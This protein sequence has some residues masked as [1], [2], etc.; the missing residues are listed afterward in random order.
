M[1]REYAR[2]PLWIWDDADYTDLSPVAQH[3]DFVLRHGPEISYCGRVDW[4]PAR[5]VPRARGWTVGAIEAAAAEY[6]AAGFGLF[7]S[8]T[9]EALVIKHIHWDELLRN[10][11]MA[12]ALVKA[13]QGLAS[14]KLRAGVVTEVRRLREECPEYSSWTHPMSRA[15]LDR[16]LAERSLEDFGITLPITNPITNRDTNPVGNQDRYETPFETGPDYQS[17]TVPNADAD[18]VETPIAAD[19]PVGDD[20]GSISALNTPRNTAWNTNQDRSESPYANPDRSQSPNTSHP[21]THGGYAMG[22]RHVAQAREPRNDPPP[23]AHHPEHP[24][25]WDPDCAQCTK[26]IEQRTAWQAD[27]VLAAEPPSPFC[28]AHPDGTTDACGACGDARKARRDHDAALA[29]A[30]AAKHT[31]KTQRAAE[32]RERAIANCTLCDADGFRGAEYG[33]TAGTRCDH[34]PATAE[35]GREGMA[36]VRAAMAGR[37]TEHTPDVDAETDEDQNDQEH[38]HV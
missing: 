16:L 9:E 19:D 18:R 29:R 12:V 30:R 7:D 36:K 3:L 6:E 34:N 5:L 28:A 14:R 10:P 13:Y 15:K 33:K 4:R 2:N 32:D 1:A 22:E 35:I 26:L 21:A 24:D 17:E 20:L 31:A 37:P 8:A 27:R 23:P 25:F 38:A 11:T